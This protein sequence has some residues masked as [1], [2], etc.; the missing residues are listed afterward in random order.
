VN[1]DVMSKTI[2]LII[3]AMLSGI[4]SAQ[5]SSP[6]VLPAVWR[7]WN[8]V[9]SYGVD[10]VWEYSM[11]KSLFAALPV[12]IQGKDSKGEIYAVPGP[13]AYVDL[14]G[15]GQKEVFVNSGQPVS[16]GTDYLILQSRGSRWKVIGE[17]QGGFTIAKRPTKG[18]AEIETW[19]RHPEQVHL[20][21][22]FKDGLYRVARR[23][24]GGAESSGWDLPF[25]SKIRIPLTEQASE[26]KKSNP[27]PVKSQGKDDCPGYK[28]IYLKPLERGGL[29]SVNNMRW[30]L[31]T[32]I[33]GM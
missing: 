28:V 26:F 25:S 12:D 23:Q 5:L 17:I 15:D 31:S 2:F 21:W 3:L 32:P 6:T 4:V 24:E 7:P 19:S 29:D 8:D 22:K 30:H 20:L 33:A 16:G 10:M 27:C 1:K 13:I 11:P 14:D 9:G 18:F